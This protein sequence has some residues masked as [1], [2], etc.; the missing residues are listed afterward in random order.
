LYFTVTDGVRRFVN[1]FLE[2]ID[3][4]GMENNT[5]ELYALTPRMIKDTLSRHIR[6]HIP[7]GGINHRLRTK[8]SGLSVD[9]FREVD[10]AQVW[11]SNKTSEEKIKSKNITLYVGSENNRVASINR[12]NL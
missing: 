8:F 7:K 5:A 10:T 9:F 4:Y 1:A 2:P 11:Y 3:V 12:L 6:W